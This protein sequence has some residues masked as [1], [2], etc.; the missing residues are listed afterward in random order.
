VFKETNV[1]IMSYKV[2]SIYL[3][4]L[5]LNVY[6]SL[7]MGSVPNKSNDLYEIINGDLYRKDDVLVDTTHVDGMDFKSTNPHYASR[8]HSAYSETTSTQRQKDVWNAIQ[9]F[10]SHKTSS[11]FDQGTLTNF[12]YIVLPVWW[13][14]ESQSN[15]MDLVVSQSVFSDINQYY[16]DMS[17]NK[18]DVTNEFLTQAVLDVSMSSPGFSETDTAARDILSSLGKVKGVDYDGIC[19]IY[20]VADAGPFSGYGGWASVNG[21]FM[22]NSYQLGVSVLRHEIG[23]NFG[24]PHHRSNSYTYRETRPSMTEGVAPYD[25]WDMMS[26]GN[27]VPNSQAPHFAAASKWFFNWIP[28]SS[29]VHMQP[30]GSTAECPQCLSSGTFT[31]RPFNDK[32]LVPSASTKMGIHIPITNIGNTVYSY[33]FSYRGTGYNGAAANGLSVHLS[34]FNTGGIF[35]ASYDSH[36]YDAFGDTFGT[37]SDSFVVDKTCYHVFPSAYMKD[38]DLAAVMQVQPVVCV[39]SIDVGNSITVTVQF[40]QQSTPPSPQ[41]PFTESTLSCSSSGA[42][43]SFEINPNQHN[44]IHVTNTGSDGIVDVTLCASGGVISGYLYDSYPHSVITYQSEA[45]YGSYKSL[46]TQKECSIV[47]EVQ[48]ITSSQGWRV[49]ADSSHTTAGWAWDIKHIKFY[50]SPSCSGT[51]I[52]NDGTA[53]DSGN[54]GGGWG[55]QNAFQTSGTWGGRSD[56]NDHFYVGMTFNSPKEVRCVE[57]LT[58]GYKSATEV[59][60][61]AYNSTSDSWENAIIETDFDSSANA[62]NIVTL[63]T[64][65]ATQYQSD[66]GE[67]F[68]VVPPADAVNS[69]NVTATVEVTCVLTKCLHNSYMLDGTCQKCPNDKVSPAGSTALSDCVPC[70]DGTFLEYPLSPSCSISEVYKTITSSQGWRVWADSSHTTSGWAWDI[71]HIKFYS[72]STCSGTPIDNDGTAFDSGNA[73]GGWGP[74]NAFQTSNAWGGRSDANDHF[75]VGMTFNS[76]RE[77][78][79]VEIL[80]LGDKSATEVRIQAYNSTTESWENAFIAKNFD[81]SSGATNTI[82]LQATESPTSSPTSPPNLLC[83]TNPDDIHVELQIKTDNKSRENK[84]IMKDLNSKSVVW[85]LKKLPK[86]KTVSYSKCVSPGGCYQVILTDRAGNGIKNGFFSVTVNGALLRSTKFR[87]GKRWKSPKFG[88]C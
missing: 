2:Y 41:V 18:M 29:I 77:V 14:D 40:I 3:I 76:P 17:W 33:W 65:I 45:A 60:I 75:Y 67:A 37:T 73:G 64:R 50:S 39:D 82:P 9:N 62:I 35:G 1:T 36:N 59:R 52:D 78:R 7:G 87:R 70:P 81:S 13:N 42:D 56:S 46:E 8:M 51:P 38:R 25:G 11:L 44:L 30:E 24:H 84:I 31:L 58:S 22:W 32:N 86:R 10:P 83:P 16:K 63:S 72:S 34:W 48:N 66:F 80:T 54:A 71:K 20:N 23:H 5:A 55:P 19:L 15:Q 53:F 28:D 69:A 79:C 43:Q 74:Q 57:I 88:S 4:S 68:I 85:R 49:W 21:D 27:G 47:D 6:F 61:Q 12:K 26:G